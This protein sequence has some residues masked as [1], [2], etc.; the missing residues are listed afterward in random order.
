M[1]PPIFIRHILFAQTFWYESSLHLRLCNVWYNAL[2]KPGHVS[3]TQVTEINKTKPKYW[4]SY[5]GESHT[6]SSQGFDEWFPFKNV[7]LRGVNVSEHL[8]AHVCKEYR[9]DKFKI[10]KQ[11]RH[12]RIRGR[13]PSRI[14]IS[15]FGLFKCLQHL[16]HQ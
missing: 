2:F 9:R 6:H 12:R 7:K 14:P 5:L 13:E 15:R 1:K 11:R 4:K 10:T 8:N 16:L 3:A